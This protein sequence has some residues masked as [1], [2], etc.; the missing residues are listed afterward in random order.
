LLNPCTQV[1]DI[2]DLLDI[3]I[4]AAKELSAS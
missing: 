2:D 3:I 1:A 4:A